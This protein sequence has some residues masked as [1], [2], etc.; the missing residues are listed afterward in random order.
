MFW[1][2]AAESSADSRSCQARLKAG[3]K[4]QEVDTKKKR[5][6]SAT[7]TPAC[8]AEKRSLTQLRLVSKVG[9]LG[10][11]GVTVQFAAFCRHIL[12]KITAECPD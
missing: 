5:K 7:F 3:S 1:N 10:F 9:S 8:Q 4:V 12:G 2:H 11:R 6:V